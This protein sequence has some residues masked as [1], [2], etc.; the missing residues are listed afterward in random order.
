MARYFA[1]VFLLKFTILSN[2]ISCG[3]DLYIYIY[4]YINFISYK[5]EKT[6]I[7]EDSKNGT[8]DNALNGMLSIYKSSF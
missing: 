4:I 8:I 7:I 1:Y 5:T 3:V 2:I 6:K